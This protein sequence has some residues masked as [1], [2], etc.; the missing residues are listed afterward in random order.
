MLGSI[1]TRAVRGLWLK[2]RVTSV[3]IDVRVTVLGFGLVVS[4]ISRALTEKRYLPDRV[5]GLTR[6]R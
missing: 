3:V 5:M 1:T 2:Y 4:V 6:T